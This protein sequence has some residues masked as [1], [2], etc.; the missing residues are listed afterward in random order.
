M[1]KLKHLEGLVHLLMSDRQQPMIGGNQSNPALHPITGDISTSN[2][3]RLSMHDTEA[4]YVGS[5][6]WIA[7]M[8][9]VSGISL[10]R[11]RDKQ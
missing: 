4:R 1:S 10:K 2:F 9:G 6:H 5:D 3:G 8:D 7:V 11:F